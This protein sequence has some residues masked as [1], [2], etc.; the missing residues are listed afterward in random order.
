MMIDKIS[1][2]TIICKETKEDADTLIIKT[3]LSL[4]PLNDN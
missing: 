1:S 4:P 3:I 2:A